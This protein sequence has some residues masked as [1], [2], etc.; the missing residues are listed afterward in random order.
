MKNES[1]S[2]R[3]I[4]ELVRDDPFLILHFPA[5]G[6]GPHH[7]KRRR[8]CFHNELHQIQKNGEFFQ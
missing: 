4:S 8:T 6:L 5:S 1:E 2:Q 7:A 3:E